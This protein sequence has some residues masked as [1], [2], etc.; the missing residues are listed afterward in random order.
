[1]DEASFKLRHVAGEELCKRT[2]SGRMYI[3]ALA[4]DHMDLLPSLNLYPPS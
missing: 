4:I 1:M 3:Y 2:I